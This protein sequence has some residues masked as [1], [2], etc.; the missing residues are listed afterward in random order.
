MLCTKMNAQLNMGMLEM[1]GFGMES[2]VAFSISEN[3]IYFYEK[4]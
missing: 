1:T 4:D 3:C 2:S